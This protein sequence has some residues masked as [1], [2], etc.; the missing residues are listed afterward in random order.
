MSCLAL[1]TSLIASYT[2]MYDVG[3][4]TKPDSFNTG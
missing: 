3:S 4:E 1:P 2:V